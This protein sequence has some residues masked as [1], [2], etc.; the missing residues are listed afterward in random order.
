MIILVVSTV[1][2]D[3]DIITLHTTYDTMPIT[4]SSHV[5]RSVDGQ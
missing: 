5:D 2:Y 1:L 3:Y 4:E